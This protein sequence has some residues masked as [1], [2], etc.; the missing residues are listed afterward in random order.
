MVQFNYL[1]LLDI[2]QGPV[3]VCGHCCGGDAGLK[4]R[5]WGR[6]VVAHENRPILFVLV[7]YILRLSLLRNPFPKATCQKSSNKEDVYRTGYLNITPSNVVKKN[8]EAETKVKRHQNR[9]RE[10]LI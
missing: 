4:W 2:V 8:E 3:V 6:P 10:D 1:T 5:W 7:L 9:E